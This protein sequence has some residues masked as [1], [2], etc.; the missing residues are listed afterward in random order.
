MNKQLRRRLIEISA[1]ALAHASGGQAPD[2]KAKKKP[3]AAANPP[4]KGPAV[5]GL[6]LPAKP[7]AEQVASAAPEVYRRN[8]KGN[9][10]RVA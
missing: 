10:D 3:V 9:W 2:P 5:A 8:E 1:R 6:G 4:P 7:A